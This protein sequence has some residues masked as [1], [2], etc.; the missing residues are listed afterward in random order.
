MV[1][2]LVPLCEWSENLGGVL[3]HDQISLQFD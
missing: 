2:M 1:Q 3:I